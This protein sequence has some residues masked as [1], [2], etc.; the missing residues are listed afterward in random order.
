MKFFD[1]HERQIL[2]NYAYRFL[3][4]SIHCKILHKYSY[5]LHITGSGSIVLLL[6][7]LGRRNLERSNLISR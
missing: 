2:Q 5:P 1:G 4:P 7:D 6:R 3:F